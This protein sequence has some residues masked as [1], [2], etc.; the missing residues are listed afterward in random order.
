MRGRT[1]ATGICYLNE[2]LAQRVQ[3]FAGGAPDLSEEQERHQEVLA[4]LE[5]DRLVVGPQGAEE[6]AGGG[7]RAGSDKHFAATPRERRTRHPV[8]AGNLDALRGFAHRGDND[9]GLVA[10]VWI[11]LP[12]R[13]RVRRRVDVT[14][15]AAVHA[16]PAIDAP[17]FGR[18]EEG[19]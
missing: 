8:V 4:V 11:V 12:L 15:R 9:S 5:P 16:E 6:D 14:V 13:H 3:P 1:L 7:N 10:E 18:S 2:R 19:R 17:A